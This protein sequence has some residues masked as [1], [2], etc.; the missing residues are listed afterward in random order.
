MGGGAINDWIVF[1]FYCY[2]V[3]ENIFPNFLAFFQYQIAN[4]WPR[5]N[6][7]ILRGVLKEWKFAHFF[8]DNL[9]SK[10]LGRTLI[11]CVWNKILQKLFIL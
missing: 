11:S 8:P 10:L 9:Y 3:V 1:F 5:S 6:S 2:F 7:N 4:F